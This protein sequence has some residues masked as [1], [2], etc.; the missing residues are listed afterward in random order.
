[1]RD[2]ERTRI[3]F[4][5]GSAYDGQ[6]IVEDAAERRHYLPDQNTIR[7]LPARRDEGLAK[8]RT[9]MRDGGVTAQPGERIAG[10]PTVEV[11]GKDTV[12]NVVQRFAIEPESGMVLRYQLYDATGTELGGFAYSKVDLSPGAFAPTLFQIERRGAKLITP[13]DQLRILAKR[14]GY[15]PVS[16]PP[17]SGYRLDTVRIVKLEDGRVL[18]QNYVGPGGRLSLYEL[19]AAVSPARLRRQGGRVLNTL[20]WTANGTTFVLVGPQDDATLARLKGTLESR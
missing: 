2:G 3:E 9:L 7:V 14:A 1:M 12:G 20:S 6:V 15:P 8:L 13:Y 18:A 5:S 4:P 10:Y 19:Q 16:L 17:S 11:T